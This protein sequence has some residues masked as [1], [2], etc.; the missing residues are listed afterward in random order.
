MNIQVSDTHMYH[1]ILH[2]LT[3]LALQSYPGLQVV[4]LELQAFERT[5]RI[6]CLPLVG[7]EDGDDGYEEDASARPDPDDGRKRQC[8]VRV[9]VE[10][11]GG[12]LQPT[13]QNLTRKT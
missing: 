7:D 11:A 12:V 4:H 9:Y 5:V 2:L 3:F 10:S 13:N 8:A 1:Q 6:P